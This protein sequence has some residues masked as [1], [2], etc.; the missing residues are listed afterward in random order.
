MAFE[1]KQEDL[2]SRSAE[3]PQPAASEPGHGRE[4][5]PGILGGLRSW[6]EERKEKKAQRMAP[7]PPVSCPWCGRKMLVGQ[8]TAGRD[9][10]KWW[11]GW[12]DNTYGRAHICVDHEGTVLSRYK[13]AWFCRSC[14]KLV[15][16]FPEEVLNTLGNLPPAPEEEDQVSGGKP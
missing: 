4:A 8:L 3:A 16:D 5:A 7:P 6:N 15:M 11:P 9:G 1:K 2:R 14:R 12:A 13:T 10:A